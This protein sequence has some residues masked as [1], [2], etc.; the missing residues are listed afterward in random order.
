[1]I[2]LEDAQKLILSNAKVQQVEEINILYA[3]GRVLAQ[4][5]YSQIDSPPFNRSP[6]DGF[7]VKAENLSSNNLFTIIDTVYAGNV[8]KKKI[9]DFEAIKIMTGAKIPEGADAI[10]RQEDT[11]YVD[12]NMLHISVTQNPYDNFIFKGEDFK[13][14]TLILKKGTLISHSE[15]MAIASLGVSKIKVFKKIIV[16]V[17]TTGDELL[18]PGEN[19][20]DGKIYN[21]NKTFL[22]FRLSELG[23]AVLFFDSI[24]DDEEAILE[25]IKSAREKCDLLISTGGV[26]V[27]EKDLVKNVVLSL[28]YDLLFWKIDIKPGSPMFAAV[29][30]SNKLYIGL[31]GTPVAAATTFELT[32]RNLLS[33]MLGNCESLKLHELYAVVEDD[34]KKVS[35]KRRFLRVFLEQ[36]R[37][38]K[39][40][41]SKVYQSPGQINT[42]L[43]SNAILEV[44]KN[45]ELKKGDLVKV[46]K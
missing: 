43:G 30:K 12:N 37:E 6:L 44:P 20:I 35:K 13:E 8:S 34:Y 31:S 9:N 25:T 14:N 10:V 3:K 33:V 11:E 4:D 5:I 2:S 32:V 46:F 23:C 42:M 39:I 36:N 17:I 26:S 45:I 21:S 27:G 41:I 29:N 15:A 19:L 22:N 24:S 18:N 7:A 40:Y 38:N 1:M 16:G 28:D